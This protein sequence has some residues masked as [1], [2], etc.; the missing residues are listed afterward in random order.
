MFRFSWKGLYEECDKDSDRLMNILEYYNG[1]VVEYQDASTIIKIAAYK[2]DSYILNL[3]RFISDTV[4]TNSEKSIYLY[5]ASKRN[6]MDYQLYK[7][8][9]LNLNA[10]SIDVVKIIHNPLVEIVNDNIYF[11]Y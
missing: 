11:K 4:A 10:A 1:K 7:V 2:K 8:D 3:K 5:L 6:I 9:C